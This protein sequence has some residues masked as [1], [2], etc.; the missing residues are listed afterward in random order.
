[1]AWPRSYERRPERQ[2]GLRNYGDGYRDGYRPRRVQTGEGELRIEIPQ[3]REAAEPFVSR[4]FR[5]GHTKRL[6]RTDPLK[7]MV[8]GA[9]VRGLSVRDVESLCEEAGLGRTSKSTVARICSELHE[10]F[11]AF[12]R[13]DLYGDGW[14]CCSD[15][16]WVSLIAP[17][18]RISPP[19]RRAE[20]RSPQAL[21]G[22]RPP[23]RDR[24]SRSAPPGRPRRAGCSG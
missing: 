21:G 8:V 20:P 5:K 9:F 17:S 7:A 10:R 14:S 16:G 2:R 18:G 13:S 1:M 3:A 23:A 15:I 12:C 24:R 19:E 11:E 6:L 22:G 4:L